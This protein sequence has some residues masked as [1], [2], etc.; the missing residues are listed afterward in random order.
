[1]NWQV[2]S[3]DNSTT[4]RATINAS[5]LL[6]ARKA[7]QVK[8]TATIAADN[9]YSSATISHT[10]TIEQ[11]GTQS[12]RDPNLS[13]TGRQPATLEVNGSHTFRASTDGNTTVTWSVTHPD[14]TATD[15][16]TIN[17]SGLLIARKAGQVKVTATV[18]ADN[19]Y[20]S[21]TLSHTL[22]I[23]PGRAPQPQAPP[24]AEAG[25]G[26]TVNGGT[27][28]TLSGSASG[29][30]GSYTYRWRQTSGTPN[31]ITLTGAN[32]ARATFTAP[33]KASAYVFTLTVDDGTTTATDTV[34]ITVEDNNNP[35]AEAGDAR[36]VGPG[37]VTLQGSGSDQ[38]GNV[39]YSWSFTSSTPPG[40]DIRLTGPNTA[41]PSFTAPNKTVDLTFTL[42]VRDEANNVASDTVT[43]TVD[44]RLPTVNAGSD[45][46]VAP[47]VKVTLNGSGSSNTGGGVTY[48]WSQ[49]G[50]STLSLSSN[51]AAAP[52]FNSPTTSGTYT[53]TLTATD[54]NTGT[55]AS[56]SVTIIVNHPLTA[57]AGSDQTV[58]I[59][60]P[61]TLAATASGGAGGNTY[62]WRQTSGTP[63]NITLTGRRT[64]QASFT[65]P[66]GATTLAF[67]LTVRDRAGSEARDTVQITINA[68]QSPNLTLTTAPGSLLVAQTAQ[69]RA[70]R[71]GEGALT[72]SIL[73][74][75]ADA[76]I[77]P[78]TG[79]LSASDTEETITVQASVAATDAHASQTLTVPVTVTD[80]VD[81]DSDGLIEIYNLTMLHNIRHD[82]QGT[83][84]KANADAE[85]ITTG[86]PQTDGCTG[87]ELVSDLDFDKDGDGTTWSGDATNGY[88]LDSGDSQRP[89][90]VTASGGWLPI[91][92][93]NR[94][95]ATF[96][97]NGFV[98]RNLAI[99]RT[100]SNVG[101]FDSTSG[102]HRDNAVS[103]R[104]LGLEQAL[105]VGSGGA[106]LVG[107]MGGGTITS[108][109]ATGVVN[110]SST[111]GGLVG[112]MSDSS[113]ISGS[114][115][116]VTVNSSGNSVG[117]LVGSQGGGT[118]T[119]SHATG[120]VNSGD[121]DRYA[122]GGLV[123]DGYG[124]ITASYATG[125]VNGGD[126]DSYSVGGLVG[127]GGRHT[128]IIITAS[129]ATG[130]VN[131]GDGRY[132]SVGGLVGRMSSTSSTITASYATGNVYGGDGASDRVGGLVGSGGSIT[133]SYATGAV[134]GGD[135][136]SDWVGGLQG[137]GGNITASYGFG[138]TTGGEE[139]TGFNG[140]EKLLGV[141]T[142]AEALTLATAGSEWNSPD[143]GTLGAWDFGDGNQPP[144]LRYS[145]YDGTGSGTNIDYCT[146]FAAAH[147]QCD[148]LIP[149]QRV[150]TTPR[151]GNTSGDI[152]LTGGDT[153]RRV[154]ANI[155]LPTTLTVE[156]TTLELMW[157]VFHDPE[158]TH[159][160]KVTIANNKLL[161]DADRRTSTRWVILR[162]TTGSGD[163]QTTVNDYHLRI[164]KVNEGDGTAQPR[165][166]N[167]H[168]IA[169]V[170][171]LAP[172]AA[173]S[174]AAVSA[175][176]NTP[177]RYRVSN[178]NLATINSSSGQLTAT[179]VGIVEVIATVAADETYRS[180]T[181]RH[182][183]SITN[184]V[185]T[186]APTR[187]HT[188]QTAQFVTNRDGDGEI[189]WS[190]VEQGT[191]ATISPTGLV[192][193][194]A[195]AETITVQAVVAATPSHP[196]ETIT[197]TLEIADFVDLDGD[198]LIDIHNLTMLHNM[199]YNLAGT[200][201][202]TASDDAGSTIG[203][204]DTGC[205]GYE[206]MSDLDFDKDNNDSTWLGNSSGYTLDDDDNAAPYF[207]VSFSAS[208]YAG[209]WKP[210]G[211][212][213]ENDQCGESSN[214]DDTPFTATFEGNGFVI[215][216]LA[217]RRDQPAIG[218]FG[219]S[220][221]TI[222]NLGLENALADYT[223]NSA[224]IYIAPLVGWMGGG[225]II[226][227]YTIG[228]AD[229]GDGANDSVGGMVG[230][231]NDGTIIASYNTGAVV[232][233]GDGASD[234][235]GGLVGY[236]N[237]GII[238][239]SYT[240][241]DVNGQDNVGGLVGYQ[242]GGIIIASYTTGDVSGQGNVGG[243]VGSQQ[244]HGTI[245]T[246][247]YTT[248]NVAGSGSVGGLVGYQGFHRSSGTITA[249]YATGDVNGGDGDDSVGGLVGH[250]SSGTL[251]ASY[252]TGDVN[253]GAGDG[254]RVGGLV[255]YQYVSYVNSN[256]GNITTITASYAS[257]DVNGG[258]GDDGEVGGLVGLMS[259]GTLTAS[260]ANGDVNGGDGDGDAVGGLVG[261]MS[262]G[263]L[264]AS[265][266]F[267]TKSGGEATRI[268]FRGDTIP[269][270]PTDGTTKPTGVTRSTDLTAANAGDEWNAATS[271]TL[272][273]WSFG[274]GQSPAL[275]YND[276]DG[277]DGTDYCLLFAAF[278]IQCGTL[279]PGQ[280]TDT[281]PQIGT[282]TSDI[283]LADGDTA[284]SITG[285]V[286]LP[287]TLTV[288]E[289]SLNLMWSVHH[290]PEKTTAN[291]VTLGSGQLI[292]NAGNRTSTRRVILRVTIGSGDDKTIVNDYRLRVMQNP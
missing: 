142:S 122:V 196:T 13:F 217:I 228:I 71:N 10:L 223:G 285:N 208:G 42:I 153:A 62:R 167:L 205:I 117:G 118:I 193:A 290:D 130:T 233:G 6:I 7:G 214:N 154:T 266:G 14:G 109:Y 200:S 194:G 43:I 27:Q 97:G 206:L 137:S 23:N 103:I 29:G 115:A 32:T 104:N 35:T 269:T 92:G 22:T 176:T 271:R 243:L 128:N 248:G 30:A 39:T 79:L 215:R 256:F 279:I 52:T 179:A 155:I 58:D 219:V 61:V 262:S 135:G 204:P 56:D 31:N 234:R 100:D 255:G 75:D 91:G 148:A 66:N 123:G 166:P 165:D 257:G 3:P 161:V 140:T 187:L 195:T 267:G 113:T 238:R 46:T 241:G 275:V 132:N 247:S 96:E 270:T 224:G 218:L 252:A 33:N 210:I 272:G 102:S 192:T 50:P 172:N 26:Q 211:D 5:G 280:R 48:R 108:S 216:N 44:T 126:G 236:Q 278:H 259:S 281:T 105:A 12:A 82:P 57:N 119:A 178:T 49:S 149:G 185:F 264:T 160:N 261:W 184:F 292:V 156:G 55:S 239:A 78:T 112:S 134:N 230:Y 240:T 159:R 231:Q 68:M 72:W 86:C 40:T 69:F 24:V 258:D 288:G 8:V 213:G 83:S 186:A 139:V 76:Y 87:Y 245:I 162:A 268:D 286:T 16:A 220:T 197:T 145:D 229:G 235:A 99:H 246:A 181:L 124:I 265:Y 110:N 221:G 4:D 127:W 207:V 163:G 188:S 51:T 144:A 74:E 227:S 98:I 70:T 291:K 120:T 289:N 60:E 63:N 277:A 94:F 180:A 15:R 143:N 28:V 242:N 158:L 222:R 250:M 157:S 34:T 11:G 19:T 146:L 84:Y 59:G 73:E 131:G 141:I 90:F 171:T 121:G 249:S 41:T 177:I 25:A 203:C 54:S 93:L 150:A 45:Q 125:T 80:K 263:T 212:C 81:F 65:V 189:T 225:A 89:Y 202:K 244:G 173:H 95:Y 111:A 168:F 254:D 170:D 47:N 85:G 282:T 174:F 147:T 64:D 138:T 283:Q 133:A 201:Y 152:Q 237:G 276:Y 190:I 9:T 273:A 284:D 287:A 151:L 20:R 21:T 38:E 36:T 129:Y 77:N 253:G 2:T 67:T 274:F 106:L 183:L 1:M 182:T 107:Y 226:A 175:H 260:Y 37:S 17:A 18:A 114:H 116:S 101:L 164:T 198:G 199:R 251:T 191:A 209:G 136:D 88:I 169:A 232:N 53:L